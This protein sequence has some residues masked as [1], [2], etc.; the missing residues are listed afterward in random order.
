M[1][2]IKVHTTASQR[3]NSQKVGSSG[4]SHKTLKANQIHFVK[5]VID[6]LDVRLSVIPMYD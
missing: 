1:L 6:Y 2:S 3:T 5:L 4:T